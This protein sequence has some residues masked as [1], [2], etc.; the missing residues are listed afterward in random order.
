MGGQTR[1]D[2]SDRGRAE[3]MRAAFAYGS[4]PAI[5]APFPQLAFI[6]GQGKRVAESAL[7]LIP[8]PIPHRT[9]T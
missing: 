7:G 3:N 4:Y 6:N 5:Y 2:E 1:I 9:R 8:I